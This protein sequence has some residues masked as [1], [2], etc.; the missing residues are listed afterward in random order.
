M[1]T[2]A[3][4]LGGTTGHGP[5]IAETAEPTF[6][7][8]WEARV[9]ALV[10][11][12][13]ATGSWTLDASRRAREDRPRNEY[14]A[15]SYYEIWLT[16][17]ER[18]LDANGLTDS[19]ERHAGRPVRP[20]RAV[21]RVL[22]ADE[23]AAALAR[24]GPTSRPAQGSQTFRVGDRV[25]TKNIPDLHHTRLPSYAQERTGVVSAVHGCHVFPDANAHGGGEQPQWLYTIEFT[26]T[27][28]FG[29]DANPNDTICLDAFEPYLDPA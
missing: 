16:A 18:L 27:S 11:A 14:L 12:M 10:L 25:R 13:G 29:T 22:R 17:L 7:S 8:E 2:A 19:E 1:N 3:S 23:V 21:A 4:H 6:H 15:M 20:P 9:L 26:A 28:L 24:G 5:V